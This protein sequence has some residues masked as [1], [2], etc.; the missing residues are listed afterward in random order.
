M[1]RRAISMKRITVTHDEAV[2]RLPPVI[3][4]R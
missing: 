2:L 4:P 3:S 1:A